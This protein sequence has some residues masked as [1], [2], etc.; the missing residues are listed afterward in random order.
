M[1]K[2][3]SKL[4]Q[5]DTSHLLWQLDQQLT[6]DF[7]KYSNR[8]YVDKSFYI[9][10]QLFFINSKYD[11]DT[12]RS[13]LLLRT[14]STLKTNQQSNKTLIIHIFS[15]K[16]SNFINDSTY[17]HNS[18][19]VWTFFSSSPLIL[20]IWKNFHKRVQFFFNLYSSILWCL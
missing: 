15:L 17:V 12:F 11:N 2:M 18:F 4:Q 5:T 20:F 8:F 1:K 19:C 7:F 14:F 10:D 3:T 9:L 6:N 13:Y 16:I